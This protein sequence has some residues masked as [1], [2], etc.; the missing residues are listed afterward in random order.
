[1]ARLKLQVYVDRF[2][3]C[4]VKSEE[5]V[6]GEKMARIV[7]LDGDT[8]FVSEMEASCTLAGVDLVHGSDPEMV[9]ASAEEE[10]PDVIVLA[11]ELPGENGYSV[12]K[13]IK[14]RAALKQVPLFIVSSDPNAEEVFAQHRRLRT[15]ADAY[16]MRP[17][18]VEQLWTEMSKTVSLPSVDVAGEMSVDI[19]DDAPME[20]DDFDVEDLELDEA[21][22]AIDEVAPPAEADL[23]APEVAEPVE[24]REINFEDNTAQLQHRRTFAQDRRV[25]AGRG[26]SAS[27]SRRRRRGAWIGG[28]IFSAGKSC[29][30]HQ[31]EQASKSR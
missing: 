12:C 19:L 29:Q 24:A 25:Q 6:K 1:M 4:N 15:K 27:D 3:A 28:D 21:F 20:L 14:K 18:S 7:L 23:A 11:I 31:S 26:G 8:N 13:R 22:D 30:S 10:I 16:L 9:L 5:H 17:I 2:A